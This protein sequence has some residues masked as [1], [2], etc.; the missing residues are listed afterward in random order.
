M[1]NLGANKILFGLGWTTLSTI[2]TG[3]TQILRLSIL[4]RFLNK[5][6]FGVVAIL[7]FVLGLT[8]VFSDLGFSASIMSEKI[9]RKIDF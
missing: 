9:Y 2:V 8:Q 1:G 4:A 6:D 7:T 5:E 3:V